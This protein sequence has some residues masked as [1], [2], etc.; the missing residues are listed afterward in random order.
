MTDDGKP[1]LWIGR[2]PL[3][4]SIMVSR[5][6]EMGPVVRHGASGAGTNL[7]VRGGHRSGAKVGSTD[8]ARIAAKMFL[9]VPSTFF[10]SKSTI[11]RFGER[12]CDGHWS[13]QFGQFLVC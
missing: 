7:K 6:S 13:V 11:S 8:P 10:G 9:V 3:K 1:Q 4:Q 2:T 5:Q 12:F